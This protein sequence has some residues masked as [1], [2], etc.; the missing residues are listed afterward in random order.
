[1][2][3]RPLGRYVGIWI[4]STRAVI[5]TPRGE[6]TITVPFD[7]ERHGAFSGSAGHP[8]SHAP[9]TGGSEKRFEARHG[10]ALE[11]FYDG[12]IARIGHPDQV[13]VFGPGETKLHLRQRLAA[14]VAPAPEIAVE[15]AETM[16]DAQ[17]IAHVA[18]HFG[19]HPPRLMPRT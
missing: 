4:D 6:H 16:S 13:L 3:Q 19:V 1:M 5:A 9:E 10:Q 8:G 12:V 7:G 17:V 14:M 2:E 11:R 18:R 15:P